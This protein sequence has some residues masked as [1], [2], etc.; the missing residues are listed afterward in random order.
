MSKAEPTIRKYMTTEPA[1]IESTRS[2]EDAD[3]IMKDLKIRHLPVM[4]D[5][6]LLGI[7]SDRDI[8]AA[9]GIIG[10]NPDSA[11]VADI[12]HQHPYQV[13]PE[14][15]LHEVLDE[16][17]DHHYG[18]V[19]VVQHDKLVGILTMIDVCRAFSEI[20]QQRFHEHTS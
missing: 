13:G 16:M 18:S 7:I 10:S 6:K 9:L 20:L 12:C 3:R 15:K 4:H 5:G 19:L 8:K 14:H 11:K 17:A 2:L 1:V